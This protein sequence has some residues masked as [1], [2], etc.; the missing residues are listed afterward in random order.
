MEYLDPNILSTIFSYV[1]DASIKVLTTV[2]PNMVKNIETVEH[3]LL[4]W[5][6][7]LGAKAPKTT[8]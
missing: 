7:G 2:N 5:P 3:D 6:Y 8:Y 4:Y 1:P